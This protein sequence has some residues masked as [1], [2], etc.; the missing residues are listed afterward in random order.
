[1]P[2]NFGNSYVYRFRSNQES[3]DLE[4]SISNFRLSSLSL[5]G[6]PSTR[7]TGSL[8]LEWAQLA[9]T[10]HNLESASEAYDQAIRLLPQVAWIGVDAIAQLKGLNSRI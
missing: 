7:I 3:A 5:K 4:E 2:Q 10:L 9:H 8:Q 1:M 6:L